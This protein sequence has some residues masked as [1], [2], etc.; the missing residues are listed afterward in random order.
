MSA[1]PRGDLPRNEG[2]RNYPYGPTARHARKSIFNVHA[3]LAHGQRAYPTRNHTAT[4]TRLD[5]LNR[6]ALRGLAKQRG[7]KGW[8]KMTVAQMKEALR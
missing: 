4:D 2:A 7:I 1:T 3:D 6:D 5:G 8:G